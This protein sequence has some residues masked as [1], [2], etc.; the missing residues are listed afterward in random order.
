MASPRIFIPNN[1]SGL[2]Q[3]FTLIEVLIVI[4]TITF[5]IG[6]SLFVDLNNYRGHAF[7][8]EH[9]ALTTLLQ[10]ARAN[11][12]NNIDQT[13]HGIALFPADHPKS[14]VL[15]EGR[16]YDARNPDMD[17]VTDVQYGFTFGTGTP[18]FVVFSQ[19]SGNA[20]YDGDIVMQDTMRN[21]N[22]KI[23]INHEGRIDS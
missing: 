13:S 8:A 23:S 18:S 12:L 1:R 22:L 9:A 3:G 16:G 6:V 14:Y 21:I 7:L 17:V 10:T 15:F 11:A 2:H 4:G 5:F 19:L 20:D